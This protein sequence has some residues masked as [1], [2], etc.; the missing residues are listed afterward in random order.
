MK[1]LSFDASKA[2][3]AQIARGQMS[4]EALKDLL[5][6]LREKGETPDEIAGAASAFLELSTPFVKGSEIVGD[7]VGTGGDGH[8]TLN[9]ST[10]ASIV[11]AQMGVKVAKHGNVAVSSKCGSADL[12]RH[13]GVHIEMTPTQAKHCLDE[14]GLTFLFAPLY[15]GGMRHAAPVRKRLGVRTIFNLLGPLLN[16]ARPDFQLTGVYDERLLKPYAQTLHK[17]GLKR[18][19]VVHGAGLDEIAVHASTKACLINEDEI[20]TLV[21]D[22]RELGFSQF[23]LSEVL[24]GDAAYNTQAVIALLSGQG[25]AA[26]NALV[27]LNAGALHWL[28]APSLS[29]KESCA[30]ARETITSGRSLARLQAFAKVSH[31]D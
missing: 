16:P 13:L 19:L 12:L 18:G 21:I 25:S 24:G 22:P 8:G 6:A 7:C 5:L 26:Y 27:A 10:P 14:V 17:L 31:Y 23:A 2:L 29:L 30:L 4:D 11:A 9:V 15:H 3:F 28:S 1:D 20:T